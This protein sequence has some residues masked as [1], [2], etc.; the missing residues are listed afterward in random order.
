MI[1]ILDFLTT[2]CV[3]ILGTKFAI[4]SANMMFDLNLKWYFL[5]DVPYLPTILVILILVFFISSEMLKDKNK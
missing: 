2:L 5:E 3:V 4:Q 1:K